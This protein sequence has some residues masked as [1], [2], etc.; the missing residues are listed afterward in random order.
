MNK[1][2]FKQ[3][4]GRMTS[5]LAVVAFVVSVALLSIG[6]SSTVA[7]ADGELKCYASMESLGW[8]PPKDY[9]TCD[10]ATNGMIIGGSCNICR[11][12]VQV[13]NG[14]K[15]C[16]PRCKAGYV[17]AVGPP[18]LAKNGHEACCYLK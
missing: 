2:V 8:N 4:V 15:N 17:W 18:D 5:A 3:V 7:K 9:E 12:N 14:R 6:F 13:E 10:P 16:K 11:G 1:S